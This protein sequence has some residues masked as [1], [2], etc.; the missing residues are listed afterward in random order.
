MP[1]SMTTLK[2]V[3]YDLGLVACALLVAVVIHQIAKMVLSRIFHGESH[4]FMQT[5]I[6]FCGPPVRWLLVILAV[7]IALELGAF[8]PGV[9]DFVTHIL[10]ISLIIV[11]AWFILALL[12][13]AREWILRRYE[14]TSPDNLHARRVHTQIKLL[15]RVVM[16]LIVIVAFGCVLMTFSRVRELGVSLLASAGIVGVILGFAAQKILAGLLAG[17]QVA[18][19]EPIRIDDV[20]I[21][22]GEWGIIEEITLTYVVVRIWD[23]R[24]LVVPMTYFLEKPFQNWT[25]T[26]AALLGTIFFYLDPTVDVEPIRAELR[27]LVE[28]S[29]LWDKKVVGL[30]ITDAKERTVEVRCLVSAANSS[31]AFDLRCMVREKL[32]TFIKETQPGALARV[33]YEDD[34]PAGGAGSAP[35]GPHI[36]QSLPPAS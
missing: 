5:I 3:L 6:R 30:Q 24:R 29:P 21:V 17:L 32:L 4:A 33:R 22:E 26:S 36:S 9:L 16:T 28:G 20:V 25:R 19:T 34:S 14:I 11:V 2:W 13:V 12:H 31:A 27:R 23:L 7:R 35:E 1:I 10:S 18:I 8:T 15:E